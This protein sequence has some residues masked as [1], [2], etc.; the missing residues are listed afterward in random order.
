MLLDLLVVFRHVAPDSRYV[1]GLNSA[2]LAWRPWTPGLFIE[3]A[4]SGLEWMTTP[5]I[6]FPQAP[7]QPYK[8]SLEHFTLQCKDSESLSTDRDAMVCL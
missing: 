2:L 3:M 1:Q 6:G 5:G 7:R 4:M 8:P